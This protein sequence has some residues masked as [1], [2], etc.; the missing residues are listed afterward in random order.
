MPNGTYERIKNIYDTLPLIIFFFKTTQ[1]PHSSFDFF[2]QR[3]PPGDDPEA[4]V[5]HHLDHLLANLD[6]QHRRPHVQLLQ[7]VLL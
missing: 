1:F 6:R 2:L 3:W 7:G 4:A 5:E